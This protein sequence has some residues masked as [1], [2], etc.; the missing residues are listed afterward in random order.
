MT[1]ILLN[2]INRVIFVMDTQLY[3][4]E[5]SGEF[6]IYTFLGTLLL[7]GLNVAIYTPTY[8]VESANMPLKGYKT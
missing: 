4:S 2:S 8:E 1:I 3:L 5:S 7:N 6:L